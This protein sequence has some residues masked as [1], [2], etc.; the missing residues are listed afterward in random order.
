MAE[1]E[2]YLL[3]EKPSE[4]FCYSCGQLRLDLRGSKCCGN[5]GSVDLRR[6]DPGT[7]DKEALKKEFRDAKTS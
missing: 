5:C 4:Y 6:G 7:L 1:I 3:T 2:I